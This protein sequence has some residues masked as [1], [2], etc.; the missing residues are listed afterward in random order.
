MI[1]S[2]P[3]ATV[4]ILISDIIEFKYIPK[5]STDN[6]LKSE[7]KDAIKQAKYYRVGEYENFRAVGVVF[8]GNKDYRISVSN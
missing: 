1:K 3:N 5:S 2:Y 6:R 8:R 7:L 4:P